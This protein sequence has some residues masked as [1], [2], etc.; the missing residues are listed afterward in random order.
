[1]ENIRKILLLT[2]CLFIT[3]GTYAQSINVTGKVIDE[4][5]LE[6]IGANISV[7]GSAGV[8]TI[9]DLNGQYTLK[10]NNPSK[11]ILVF[12]FIGMRTQEVHVKGKNGLT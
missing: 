1:M 6:V 5:G 8:G 2:S 9:T 4:E 7:K 11:D 3:L 10:V 12:S